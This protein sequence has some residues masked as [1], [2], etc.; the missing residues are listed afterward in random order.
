MNELAAVG[1]HIPAMSDMAI[2]KVRKLESLSLR[3]PQVDIETSHFIHG[4]I[5]TRTIMIPAG[6]M[7][8]GVLIKVATILIIQGDV[9]AYIGDNT[10]ELHGYNILPASANRKQA[11]VAQTDTYMTMIFPSKAKNI[12]EAEEEFT[13]ET[14]MLISRKHDMVNQTAITG[15]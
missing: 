3:M 5:Y 11:F 12:K 13:D 2:D 8:T 14:H 10:I 15:E 1:N 7:I 4:G 9:T 6:V